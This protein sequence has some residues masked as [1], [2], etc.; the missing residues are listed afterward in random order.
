MP[1]AGDAGDQGQPARPLVRNGRKIAE[2]RI[3]PHCQAEGALG[4]YEAQRTQ[5]IADADCQVVFYRCDRVSAHKT[6]ITFQ[7]KRFIARSGD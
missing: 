6:K 7:P 2:W 3:C 4:V 5:Q 1:Q